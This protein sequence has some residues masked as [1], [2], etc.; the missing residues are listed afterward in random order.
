M[1]EDRCPG[2][3]VDVAHDAVAGNP[4]HRDE[5]AAAVDVN[6][7]DQCPR[8]WEPLVEASVNSD[9]SPFGCY[10]VHHWDSRPVYR[11]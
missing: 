8:A 1:A 6:V 3:D 10:P 9:H 7:A 11:C 4:P 2:R 5:D